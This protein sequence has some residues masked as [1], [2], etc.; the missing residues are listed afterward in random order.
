MINE[1]GCYKT[2][3]LHR[4]ESESI[5]AV[6]LV[7]IFPCPSPTI[8]RAQPRLTVKPFDCIARANMHNERN[9]R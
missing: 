3:S 4:E 7:L 8:F 6:V 1:R 5:F 2:C 9:D